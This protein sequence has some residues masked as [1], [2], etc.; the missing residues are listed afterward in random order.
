VSIHWLPTY[1]AVPGIAYDAHHQFWRDGVPDGFIEA[2]K[3][4]PTFANKDQLLYVGDF[5]YPERSW[6]RATI[7]ADSTYAPNMKKEVEVS[8]E[9]FSSIVE[10]AV[11]AGIKV[12][13]VVYPRHPDY[14]NTGTYGAFGPMRS[15]AENIIKRVSKLDLVMLDENKGGD[16]DYTDAMAYDFDHLSTLGAKQLTRR[17]DSL[18]NTLE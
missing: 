14:K 9:T 4:A 15:Y 16:H 5:M 18:L 6:G 7:M 13:G 12:V 11:E 8:F 1:N 17:V 2:V 10:A 3:N